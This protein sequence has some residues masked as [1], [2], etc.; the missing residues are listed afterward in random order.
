[1]FVLDEV[2]KDGTD[3][4][5]HLGT[6]EEG[7][8]AKSNQDLAVKAGHAQEGVGEVDDEMA[9][10]IQTGDKAAQRGGLA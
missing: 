7:F 5:D 4:S 2:V 8:I 10:S 6:T 9:I 3:A 1:M